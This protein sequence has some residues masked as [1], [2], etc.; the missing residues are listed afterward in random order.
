MLISLIYKR[1]SK[2]DLFQ[3]IIETSRNLLIDD[4]G[5]LTKDG[6]FNRL[7]LHE[8]ISDM[9]CY[10]SILKKLVY[11]FSENYR[12]VKIPWHIYHN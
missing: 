11:C 9:H 10:F 6:H 12:K 2:L 1:L 8:V 5:V 3:E 7:T 4:P